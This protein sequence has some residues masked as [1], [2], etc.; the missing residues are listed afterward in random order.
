MLAF[1]VYPQAALR[2]GEQAVPQ[3]IAAPRAGDEPVEPVD[4]VQPAAPVPGEVQV[5]PQEQAP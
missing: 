4:Q 3:S 2:D 5:P 1:A